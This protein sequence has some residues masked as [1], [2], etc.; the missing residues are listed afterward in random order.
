M[1]INLVSPINHLS[2]G[3]CGFNFL[4]EL[5]LQN[6]V[7]LFPIGGV[8]AFPEEIPL[9]KKAIENS[10]TYDV[11]APCIRLWH[12]FDMTMFVGKNQ[13]IGSTIFEL[14]TFTK[15]EIHQLNSLDKLIVPTNWAKNVVQN[16]NITTPTY[17]VPLG[18]NTDIFK[19]EAL[20][21]LDKTVFLVCG[22]F[23]VRKFHD[24][25]SQ[26]FLDA[27]RDE[28]DVL[29]LVC[30]DNQFL[31]TQELAAFT[32]KFN[33]N[34]IRLIPRVSTSSD[35]ASLINSVHCVVLPSRAEGWN[36]PAL[37]ALACGKTLITTNYS[38]HTE[39]CNSENSLLVDID[40]VEPAVDNKWFFGNGNWATIGDKQIK[41][42]KDY[43]RL[44]H[45][46]RK[47]GRLQLNQSGI[48]TAKTYTWE[49]ATKKL[50]T[51]VLD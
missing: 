30:C 11:N 18:V 13:H 25:I 23:E 8:Q 29:L 21:E 44:V 48:E 28:D 12:Q 22:K 43:L 37:E 20:P 1:N 32:S 5:S 49:N 15:K 14:D 24:R 50:I 4:K 38:A 7:S 16:N 47:A 33:H 31:S 6:E 9:I 17:V 41:Q 40:S 42:I 10:E 35:F 39:F 3:I 34:K 36:L 26:V 46:N 27:F 2:Y 51:A 45:E 19:P